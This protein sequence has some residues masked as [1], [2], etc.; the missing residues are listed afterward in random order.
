MN[1]QNSSQVY[2][3]LPISAL[4]SALGQHHQS[5][6]LKQQCPK[7]SSA[8]DVAS[9]LTQPSYCSWTELLKP[10]PYSSMIK[11]HPWFPIASLPTKPKILRL[12]VQTCESCLPCCPK[13]TILS[14]HVEPWPTS[15]NTFPASSQTV[16]RIPEVALSFSF[17]DPQV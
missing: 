13:Y 11:I 3:L 7:G 2:L 1:T 15:L 10:V 6:A 14:T 4:S 16:P 8:S 5:A 17:L 9:S 12:T